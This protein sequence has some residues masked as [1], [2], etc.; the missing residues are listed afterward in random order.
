MSGATLELTPQ[1]A[2]AALRIG[3][4]ASSSDPDGRMPVAIPPVAT[5]SSSQA[6]AAQRRALWDDDDDDDANARR[7]SRMRGVTRKM[8]KNIRAQWS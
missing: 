1:A 7:P 2:L 5:A 8:S 3:G 6:D 4:G